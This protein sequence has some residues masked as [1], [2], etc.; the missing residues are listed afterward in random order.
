MV[1]LDE[2]AGTVIV[3]NPVH[4]NIIAD[5]ARTLV[6]VPRTPGATY[7]TVLDKKGEVMMQRHVIVASPKKNYIRV[8]RT[9][10]AD[11]DACKPISVYYCPDMC[12][13]ILQAEQEE[14]GG[15]AASASSG[16]ENL[17]G[18]DSG[19]G[20]DEGTTEEE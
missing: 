1:R 9:C 11:N 5:S 17:A 18:A 10:P 19:A 16:A 20:S 4:I 3:G 12:H 2:D 13:E 15:S 7:F 14:T 8:R 6:V